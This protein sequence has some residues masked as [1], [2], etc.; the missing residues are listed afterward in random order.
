[1]VMATSCDA[2][3]NITNKGWPATIDRVD[4]SLHTYKLFEVLKTVNE[5]IN[6]ALQLLGMDYYVNHP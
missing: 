6:S 5:S 3:I 1:M 4:I 2:A